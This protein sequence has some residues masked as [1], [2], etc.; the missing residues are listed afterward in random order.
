MSNPT[1]FSARPVHTA[2]PTLR[3]RTERGGSAA[4]LLLVGLAVAAGS[5]TAA[6]MIFTNVGG[7][8]SPGLFLGILGGVIALVFGTLFAGHAA[9]AHR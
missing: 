3:P 4:A 7:P 1:P 9:H 5:C 2:T 8:V 6:I